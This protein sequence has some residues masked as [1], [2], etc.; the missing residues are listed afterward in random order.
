MNVIARV[1]ALMLLTTILISPTVAQR[2][3]TPAK[4]QPKPAAT[5]APTPAPTFDTLLP[6]DSYVVYAE[7]RDAG[8][9]IRS[10]TLSDLLEPILKLAG[11]SKE[12]KSVV[13]WLNAHADQVM[14][15]RLAVAT[16]PIKN[17]LPDAMVIIEFAS[18]EEAAKFATPLNEFLPTVLP[19]PQSEPNSKPAKP[20]F[21]LERLGS[22]VVISPRP[23][24]MKELR[25]ANGK[26]L[27]E[28]VNFRSARN[29]FNAEPLFAFVNMT[30]I[31]KEDE[32][33]R[34]QSEEARRKA[35][36]QVKQ[37]AAAK[38]QQNPVETAPSDSS[39]G[40]EEFIP[41]KQVTGVLVASPDQPK[42]GPT[43]DPTSIALSSLGSSLFGG[44]STW[45]DAIG[46]ALSYE[47][48]SLDLRA[49][50]I[51]APGER[52]DAIPFWPHIIPGTAMA[53]ESPNIF[54][55][56][57]ELFATMSLDLPQIYAEMSK[58]V[59]LNVN[60]YGRV[61]SNEVEA[62][63]PFKTIEN[64]LQINI[65]DEL[66]PLLGSE[67]AV[68]LPMEGLNIAGIPGPGDPAQRKKENAQDQSSAEKGP[69]LAI[70]VK[71]RERL[72]AL[73]PKLIDALGFKGVS[74]FAQTERRDDTELVS[75]ANLFAYAFVG[76]FLVLS[77][78]PATTRHVV[79]SYLKQETL[80]SDMHFRAYTRWQP[81]PLHGQFYI[82]PALMEG[83]AK[84]AAQPTQFMGDQMRALLTRLSTVAQ[85]ITYSLSNEG[86]GPL[87]ELHLPKNLV[88][89]LVAGISGEVN[90]PPMLQNE[91]MAIGLM[92][93][94]ARAEENYKNKQGGGSCGTLEDLFAAEL[95]SKEIVE[96]S[97][98][99]FDVTV[100]GDKFEVSAVPLEYG[101]TGRLSLFIDHTR[102]IRGGDRNGA[103]ATASDT[104]IN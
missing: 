89:M 84:F 26:S 73:M 62:E 46:L 51:N 72:R 57:T 11:P 64:R 68:G 86:Q 69:I 9:L 91:R 1:A 40:A 99:K 47:G 28:D 103:I 25:P 30:L 45:P 14:S 83:Y 20:N 63:S 80:S 8:Q 101:K 92:Y 102:V 32:E 52:N 34:K 76:N 23:W 13:K 18:P 27:S 48:E 49:L 19:T 16:W 77:S 21:H 10:N 104:P 50:L 95:I 81:R 98:Y 12:F 79:D 97:G 78:D 35:T 31:K 38:E 61:P 71:D 41:E 54:P 42:E 70:A 3:Q 4:T 53:P 85:P 87:H 56:T 24:T 15:S 75:Y 82:S 100:S 88:V 93:S 5:A 60:K 94:I 7:V 29:R 44:E 2:R 6:A 39:S 58:P 67:I 65:K 55:A 43:P 36:E 17:N 96:K 59:T 22:L 37:E 74:Q 90:P 33:R 66:L